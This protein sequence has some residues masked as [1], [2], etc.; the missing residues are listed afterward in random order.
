MKQVFI[1]I[2]ASVSALFVLFGALFGIVRVKDVGGFNQNNWMKKIDDSV[3]LSE[4]SIPGTHDSGALYEPFYQIA[5]CQKYTIR[6]QLN[7]GVRF[8]DVRASAVGNNLYISHGPV[9]QAQSVDSVFNSCYNFLKNN[10]GETIVM[11]VMDEFT[12]FDKTGKT[13]DL[14][15]SKILKNASMW[16]LEDR[17]PTLG[18]VR[19]KIVLVNRFNNNLGLTFGMMDVQ[20]YYDMDDMQ[21]GWDYAYRQFVQCENEENRSENWYIN[22]L[23]GYTYI[24]SL[25]YVS[26]FMNVNFMNY[27]KENPYGC[28]G[29]VIFDYIEPAYCD[30]V[31]QS[32]FPVKD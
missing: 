1:Q 23:S 30:L 13:E 21:T 29:T 19:G 16:Y 31:I 24:G 28:K 6:D 12:T 8:L 25:K 26:D 4:I 18:E 2:V 3:L 5:K 7:M 17:Y 20:D 10:P 15:E 9:F 11:S 14:I 22:F 27:M 32:N